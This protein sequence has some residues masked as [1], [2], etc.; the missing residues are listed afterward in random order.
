MH[1]YILDGIRVIVAFCED[2]SDLLLYELQG[3]ILE[4][5]AY[6]KKTWFD[7]CTMEML[8]NIAKCYKQN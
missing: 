7:L 4:E 3:T 6:S 5:I 2:S 1:A 8:M